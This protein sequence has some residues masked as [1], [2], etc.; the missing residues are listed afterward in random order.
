MVPHL[1]LSCHSLAPFLLYQGQHRE[2]LHFV[3]LRL[4]S[5]TS[6]YD[7]DPCDKTGSHRV[8]VSR[9]SQNGGILNE[10]SPIGNDRIIDRVSITIELSGY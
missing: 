2:A 7:S 8:Q 5:T 4:R 3:Y 6:G 1:M 10:G 9:Q